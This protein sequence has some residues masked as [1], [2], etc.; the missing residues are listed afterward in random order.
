MSC[1]ARFPKILETRNERGFLRH[2][3]GKVTLLY[4]RRVGSG[5]NP[6]TPGGRAG[7]QY[8]PKLQGRGLSVAIACSWCCPIVLQQLCVAAGAGIPWIL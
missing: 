5:T 6:H 2:E 3:E 4:N 1:S 7:F 8:R